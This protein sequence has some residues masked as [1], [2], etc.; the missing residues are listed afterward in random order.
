MERMSVYFALK[1]SQRRF[2]TWMQVCHFSAQI[3]IHSK[4]HYIKHHLHRSRFDEPLGRYS[5]HNGKGLG[6]LEVFPALRLPKHCVPPP[7]IG[8]GGEEGWRQGGGDQSGPGVK[9]TGFLQHDVASSSLNKL[10]T[11][12]VNC[13]GNW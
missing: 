3:R 11:S 8:V 12:P 4:H 13:L 10:Q 5:L 7:V 9:L 2:G 6:T 1:V